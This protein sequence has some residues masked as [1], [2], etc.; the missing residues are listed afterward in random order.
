MN[1]D[2][3]L[4]GTVPLMIVIFGL[5]EMIKSFGLKGNI[6]TVISMLLGVSFGISFQIYKAGMPIGFSAW[7]EIVVFG[8]LIGLVASGFYKFVSERTVKY[9]G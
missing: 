6:L 9:N 5:V 8:L 7:F 1:Y 2:S 4:V 3:L